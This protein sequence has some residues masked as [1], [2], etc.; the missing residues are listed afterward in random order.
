MY[1]SIIWILDLSVFRILTV[2][3]SSLKCHKIKGVSISKLLLWSRPQTKK[4]A[5]SRKKIVILRCHQKRLKGRKDVERTKRGKISNILLKYSLRCIS[6]TQYLLVG[7]KF[8]K[9]FLSAL[10]PCSIYLAENGHGGQVF[11]LK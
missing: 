6:V 7:R 8:Y 3:I 1:F 10:R 11:K 2:L 5:A 9:V 4:S